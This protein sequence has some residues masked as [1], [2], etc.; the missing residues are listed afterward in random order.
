V[1][2]LTASEF[3]LDSGL[4]LPAHVTNTGVIA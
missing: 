3:L 1:L 4:I 2:H